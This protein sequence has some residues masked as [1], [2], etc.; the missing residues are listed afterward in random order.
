[1][2]DGEEVEV[3]PLMQEYNCDQQLNKLTLDV[4]SPAPI[5]NH[6]KKN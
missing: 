3:Q 5:N 4:T 2:R 6:F 1:M